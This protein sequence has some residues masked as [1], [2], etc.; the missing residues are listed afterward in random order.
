MNIGKKVISLMLCLGMT[1]SLA[2][3][4]PLANAA[5]GNVGSTYT[6]S[7]ASIGTV[8]EFLA[9]DPSGVYYLSGD[10]DFS[11]TTYKGNVYD[12]SFKGVLDGNGHSL[13]GITVST[14][15]SDAGIF[16]N[17][18]SG[19]IKNLTIGSAESP[20]SITS[21]GEA[22]SVAAIAGTVSAGATFEN[23]CIY[24]NVKGDGKTAGFT[25]YLGQGELTVTSCE[26]HGSV[27]GNPAA[28]F[29]TM[30]HDGSSTIKIN[31]SFNYANV[32]GGN[33]GAGGFYCTHSRV[34]SSR[35]CHLEV[36]GCANF[37]TIS[38]TD[39][40][41]GGI[42]GEFNETSSSTLKVDYCYNTGAIT[43]TG[44]GGFAA[45]IVGGMCFDAPSGARSITNVYNIGIV[46]N[47]ANTSNA[48]AIAFAHSQS[49]N[50]TV[51]N[52]AYTEGNATQNTSDTAVTQVSDAS[53]LLAA[54]KAYPASDGLSFIPDNGNINNG[55]PILSVQSEEHEHTKKYQCGRIICEDCG[56]ILSS[57][58]DEKHSFNDTTV[59]P[60]GYADGYIISE[61]RYCKHTEIRLGETGQWHVE[62]SDGVYVLSSPE[63]LM[64]YA[65]SVRLGLLKGSE[66]LS[67]AADL[68]MMN[69]SFT[70]I[71]STST[72][73]TGSLEGNGHKI[74]NLKIRDAENG[75]LFAVLGMGAKVRGLAIDRADI[76][77]SANAG[78][79]A[80][81]AAQGAVVRLEEIAVTTS[82]ILTEAGN[83]GGII[84]SCEGSAE[85]SIRCAVCDATHVKGNIAGGAVG[86]GNSASLA[87]VYVNTT[88]A[89]PAANSGYL[90][91]HTSVFSQ[92]NC[93]YVKNGSASVSDGNILAKYAFFSGEIAYTINTMGRCTSFGVS[94]GTTTLSTQ[95]KMVRLGSEKIY[96][97]KLL[98][99][100][101]GTTVWS[102]PA[103]DG[104]ILVFAHD[105]NAENR[106]VD[107]E[108]KVDGKVIPMSS[109]TLSRYAV[110][111]NS[112]SAPDDASVL[113]TVFIEGTAPATVT[114]GETQV[115]VQSLG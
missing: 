50:V 74:S 46:R 47:T 44:G 73:F 115:S 22:F 97:N 51:K 99:G 108:I 49:G 60:D 17:N 45:G 58:D 6:P 105:R 28:G 1:L 63:E 94:Q 69:F 26:V 42:V 21:T 84:G 88:L 110:S 11:G 90:A 20:A 43:M 4:F 36:I 70:P 107:T 23:I 15:N 91:Y 64:W 100:N 59:S 25:S 95:M 89:A 31:N 68:D 27:A 10:I 66:N 32:S 112:Y 82:S 40:R 57:P 102:I 111:G 41:V 80:G 104:V 33:L 38:A 34:D 101:G 8:E 18:F 12:R 78:A 56:A 113:Y 77:A 16:A 106:L 75:G 65:A 13:L 39:W 79:I 67:L 9:M 48:Y 83:A 2:G 3:I 53:S 114:L 98:S 55:Y 86:N 72:P 37:G 109:L 81:R 52:A 93:G 7:G 19:T 29:V 62:E 24:A 85:V 87:F 5:I 76:I 35:V 30:A 96:T 54:V 103:K 92:K 71:G 14:A 61:C